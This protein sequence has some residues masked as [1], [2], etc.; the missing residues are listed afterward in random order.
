M[1]SFFILQ[2]IKMENF[3]E[4]VDNKDKK[5]SQESINNKFKKRANLCFLSIALYLLSTVSIFLR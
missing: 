3:V 5:N 2:N 4:F 1:V